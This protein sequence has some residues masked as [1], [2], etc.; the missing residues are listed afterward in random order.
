MYWSLLPN[1]IP[2]IPHVPDQSFCLT[3]GNKQARI[4]DAWC[5]RFQKDSPPG[6]VIRRS[7]SFPKNFYIDMS[8]TAGLSSRGKPK[9]FLDLRVSSIPNLFQSLMVLVPTSKPPYIFPWWTNPQGSKFSALVPT[10]IWSTLPY[11]LI[12]PNP[13]KCIGIKFKG[14]MPRIIPPISFF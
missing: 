6:R 1:F 7:A 5:Y 4:I 3:M 13:P 2:L 14:S 12:F 10:K 8:S 11:P 9:S